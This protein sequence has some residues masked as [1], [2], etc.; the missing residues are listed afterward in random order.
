[1][2]KSFL[3]YIRLSLYACISIGVLAV[4]LSSSRVH[5]AGQFS[6]VLSGG[7]LIDSFQEVSYND[8]DPVKP[9][10]ESGGAF[11]FDWFIDSE[12]SFAT[13]IYALVEEYSYPIDDVGGNDDAEES[14]NALFLGYRY[15]TPSGWYVGPGLAFLSLLGTAKGVCIVDGVCGDIT[16]ETDSFFS[17]SA[18]AITGG[19][20]HTS[21]GGFVIG[22][23]LFDSLPTDV[24][25]DTVCLGIICVDPRL[26]S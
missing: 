4:F 8:Q 22:A 13:D 16:T 23:H 7:F 20:Q 24:D 26:Y 18:L 6:Y 25:I 15:H 12:S 1:M 2:I 11:A 10:F 5:A 21:S 3:T 9:E 14:W 19:W 17:N